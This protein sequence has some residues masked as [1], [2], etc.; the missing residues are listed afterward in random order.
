MLAMVRLG[1]RG[2]LA[3]ADVP[4]GDWLD[5][6]RQ[7]ASLVRKLYDP[8][9]VSALNEDTRRASAAYAIQVFQGSLLSNAAGYVVGVPDCPLG[10]LYERLP[11]AS[12]CAPARASAR[13]VFTGDAVAGVEL[14]SGEIARRPT[15]WSS[16]PATTPPGGSSRRSVRKRTAA[17]AKA[18]GLKTSRS[19]ASTSRSTA[20]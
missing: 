19:S 15:P 11:A 1:E 6:Q 5:A 4:F 9:I 7:P 18:S 20:R 2:R 17:S 16:R 8:V 12:T 13:L 10:E 3:L 14:Q